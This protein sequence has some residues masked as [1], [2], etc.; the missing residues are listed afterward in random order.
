M[1]W[2]TDHLPWSADPWSRVVDPGSPI[3]V[4]GFA[5]GGARLDVNLPACHWRGGSMLSRSLKVGIMI[6]ALTMVPF[7]CL[8]MVHPVAVAVDEA[9]VVSPH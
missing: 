2:A 1:L 6:T 9:Q 4:A 8:I 5:I 7:R 3:W